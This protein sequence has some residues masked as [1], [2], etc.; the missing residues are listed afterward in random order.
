MKEEK[1]QT[2]KGFKHMIQ[3]YGFVCSDLNISDRS[4][5]PISPKQCD[6][7]SKTRGTT[8]RNQEQCVLIERKWTKKF[9]HNYEYS[10]K[11]TQEGC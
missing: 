7:I 8:T 3:W 4:N 1:G 11:C 6:A 10:S 5:F 9:T 2:R